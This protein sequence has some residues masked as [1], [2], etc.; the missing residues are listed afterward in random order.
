MKLKI[1]ETIEVTIYAKC[2]WN[3][4]QLEILENEEYQLVLK[5]HDGTLRSNVI[6]GFEIPVQAIFDEDLNTQTL[7]KLW[8]S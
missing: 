6:K 8:K 5:S 1:N 2:Q 4:T 7:E 3:S